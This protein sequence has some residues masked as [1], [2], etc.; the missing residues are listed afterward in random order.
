MT[1]TTAPSNTNTNTCANATAAAP[2]DQVIDLGG[3]TIQH[4]PG[5][6]RAYL[7]KLGPARPQQ[8]LPPLLDLCQRHDY[9]KIFAKVPA[10]HAEPFI[11]RGFETE[12]RV[13]G[14]YQNREDA[15]FLGLYLK[16]ERRKAKQAEDIGHI[17]RLARSKAALPAPVETPAGLLVRRC[18]PE[19]IPA[20][21]DIYGRVFASYP[22][23]IADHDFL[24][25][26][27][28]SHV[29]Y[30][31]AWENERLVAL[32]SAETDRAE[33]NAE[34]TDFATLPEHRGGGY[35]RILLKHLE[36][37]MRREGVTTAY[38]IARAL[39]PGMNITFAR[40][41]YQ[42]AGCLVN[43][44]NICGAIESMNV[45]YRHLKPAKTAATAGKTP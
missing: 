42:F 24:A 15:V 10:R 19:D 20:M 6:R 40:Q 31:G 14:F 12:A 4:G 26:T 8:I 23:P 44:T 28:A 5:N 1:N 21:A 13:P 41:G 9:G 37:E 11:S 32:A 36:K 25:E 35:A 22:F 29:V 2:M 45:W 27:M 3:A 30:F 16:P 17:R 18:T 39:S 33:Q 38:T 43:N 7:M 34:M